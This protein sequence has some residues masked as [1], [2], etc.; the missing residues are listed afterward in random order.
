MLNEEPNKDFHWKS[1]LNE[2][3]AFPGDAF[4]KEVAWM[5]LHERMQAKPRNT[6]AIW[7]WAAAACALAAVIIPLLFLTTKK[8]GII[9][10]S[11]P[12]KKQIELT[13]SPLAPAPGKSM[14]LAL[15]LPAPAKKTNVQ[16]IM[17]LHKADPVPGRRRI[18]DVTASVKMRK[19]GNLA[20][21]LSTQAIQPVH[22]AITAVVNVPEK[23][24]LPVVHENELGDAEPSILARSYERR[25]FQ[26]KF[27]NRQLD[28]NPPS[29]GNTGFNIFKTTPPSN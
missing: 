8:E 24:R 6:K 11:K 22:N 26:V 15:S 4:N 21:V 13:K 10:I 3:E 5:R 9:A 25:S 19:E 20:P 29:S 27:I 14:P 23:K 28:T 12:G 18:Q 16:F 7:Y 1:K 2:L 17:P